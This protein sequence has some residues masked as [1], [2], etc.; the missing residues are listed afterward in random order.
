MTTHRPTTGRG[1]A[2]MPERRAPRA[3]LDALDRSGS[4]SERI[5]IVIDGTTCVFGIRCVR[6]GFALSVGVIPA[7]LDL[8]AGVV[9]APEAR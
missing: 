9:L 3:A 8:C 6:S 5:G 4:G 7:A 1:P 2:L